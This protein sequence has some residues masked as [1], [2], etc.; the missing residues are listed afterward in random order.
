MGI[1]DFVQSN[2]DKRVYSRTEPWQR[3]LDFDESTLDRITYTSSRIDNPTNKVAEFD[4][5]DDYTLDH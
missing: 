1:R 2:I 5:G 3:E 4:L